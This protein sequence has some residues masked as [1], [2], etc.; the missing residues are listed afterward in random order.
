MA[1]EPEP[2]PEPEP[3]PGLVL[4][5][6]PL[7]NAVLFPYIGMPLSAGRP[8]SVSAIESAVASEEKEILVVAQRDA[9]VQEPGQADLFEI[10]TKAVIRRLAPAPQGGVQV[11][12]QGIQRVRIVAMV[13]TEPFLKAGFEPAPVALDVGADVEAL[14]REVKDSRDASAR[15]REARRRSRPLSARGRGRGPTTMALRTRLAH[16][17]GALQGS[18]DSRV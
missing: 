3:K 7:K 13:S 8:V 5:V 4:P 17:A 10:G 14:E 6:F 2:E 18:G 1:S 12:V 16:G 9:A 11:F 15:P